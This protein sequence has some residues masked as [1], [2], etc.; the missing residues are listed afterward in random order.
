MRKKMMLALVPLTALALNACATLFTGTKDTINFN[1]NPAGATVLIDGIEVG[2]TP[3]TVPVKRSLSGKTVILRMAGYQ[4]RTFELSQE[5]NVVSVLN[6]ASILG[7]GIDAATGS[8]MK[9]DR[10]DYQM[11]LER[12]TS[13]AQQL[14]V[15]HVVLMD[16]LA[17]DAEGNSII[18]QV[19]GGSIAIVDTQTQQVIVAK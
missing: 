9:Y 11:D 13:M 12:R 19:F 5:F 18:P 4:D 15:Q 10:K 14:G 16:E 1:S 17:R 8:I 3:I 2:K 7:W 6:L